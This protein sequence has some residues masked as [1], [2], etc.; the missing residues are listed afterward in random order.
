M[1]SSSPAPILSETH[2]LANSRPMPIQHWI[3]YVASSIP[4]HFSF[5]ID[6]FAYYMP[7]PIPFEIHYL[8]SNE[9]A[10]LL[11]NAMMGHIWIRSRAVDHGPSLDLL[12][13][14]LLAANRNYP[15]SAS[16]GPL[17]KCLLGYHWNVCEN[18]LAQN[19]FS[20]MFV[21]NLLAQNNNIK[22][23]SETIFPIDL[24]NFIIM[25]E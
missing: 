16:N 10:P 2:Y 22:C 4:T 18:L 19:N 7:T 11:Q 21:K 6:S 3:H 12:L 24:H 8:A 9:P 15:Y 23:L 14:R 17:E 20:G 1:A 5:V 13:A 25:L